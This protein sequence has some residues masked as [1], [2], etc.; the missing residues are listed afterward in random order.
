VDALVSKPY[1]RS[2]ATDYACYANGETVGISCRVAPARK[3]NSTG[4]VVVSVAGRDCKVLMT[5][6][7][8]IEL[9]P[10]ETKVIECVFR[11]AKFASDLYTVRAKLTVA[12]QVVD[13]VETGFA[14]YSPA[15]TASGLKLSLKGNYF[16]DGERPVLMSG[17]NETG[18]VFHSANENPLVWDR[19]LARMNENGMNILRVLHFSPFVSDT[20][21]AN[22]VKPMDLAL[23]QLPKKIERQLDALVQL[24]QRHK[25]VL[26]LTLHDW[27]PEALT[28]A[29]LAAQRKFAKLIASRY[30]DTP[31]FMID[32]Q[33]EPNVELPKDGEKYKSPD[34]VEA[35]NGYLRG[36]YGTDEALSS[37]WHLSPPESVLGSIPYRTGTGA[38]DDMR[39]FDADYFRNVIIER[40]ADANRAGA[41]EGDQDVQVTVGFLQEYWALNKLMGTE[42][43]D[44]ANMHS[45]NPIEVLRADMKLFDRRFQGKSLSLGEF[46]AV[47]DHH[48]RTAGEDN[49][50]QDY[51]R[52]LLSGHYLF[53]EGGSFLAN[54]CWK[55]MDDAVFPWGINYHCDG[56][57]KNIMKAYRNQSLLMRPVQPMYYEPPHVL[58]VV[59]LNAMIGGECG[60]TIQLLYRTVDA[61]LASHADFGVI[62]DQHLQLLDR[63]A[64]LLVYPAPM[65]IPD[66]AYKCLKRFVE[67]GGRLCVTGDVSY[68]SLRRRTLPDRLKELCGVE[69]VSENVTGVKWGDGGK[70]CISVA[71]AG[72][73]K[74]GECYVYKLGQGEVRFTPYPNGTPDPAQGYVFSKPLSEIGPQA[75]VHASAGHAFRLKE[76]DGSR[77]II[78]VNPA[79]EPA[80]IAISEPRL[81]PVRVS[82][83]ANGTG[84]VRYDKSGQVVA[85]EAQ[86]S[87]R[88]GETAIN[89]RGHFA[90]VACDGRDLLSSREMVVL[91]FGMADI[92]LG[93][94]G[95]TSDLVVEV[96]DVVDGGWKKLAENKGPVIKTT[97]ETA[98]D[99]HIVAPK[100]RLEW[101]GKFVASE[102]MLK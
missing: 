13:T 18:A 48:R 75:V 38:W 98:F 51:D 91:P 60:Q 27:M 85:V 11:P 9:K 100:A 87:V 41:R 50:A 35:W 61:L 42:H 76:I 4:T 23:D 45:Y 79:P 82:L 22:A 93:F 65:H 69:F 21:S 63:D 80:E 81:T 57:R 20:P 89:A 53:G 102:L 44:F 43:L 31:G 40:W 37:A 49:P 16:R 28:N 66:D 64:K 15:V 70:P 47:S 46:G 33:N 19:D 52:F 55:D 24:C 56:P 86:G 83:K 92:D 1:L 5:K 97:S 72:A 88:I 74:D 34:V 84:I 68:D 90:L 12:G 39:T 6:R 71:P 32:I 58:L 78:L 59:P 25:V 14:A 73:I 94:L 95:D 99:I 96:G 36:R 101:L 77:T 26:F 54:W 17:T 2:L 29:E 10:L 7:T 3:G 67:E 62:D 30:R 8:A